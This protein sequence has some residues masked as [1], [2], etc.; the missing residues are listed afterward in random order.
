MSAERETV[1]R[2]VAAFLADRVGAK[3]QARVSGDTRSGLF[4]K[5][6][7]TGAD[8]YVP[9]ATLGEEYYVYDEDN[10]LLVGERTREAYRLGDKVEVRL[11]EAIP[12]AG[13]LRFEVLTP[14]TRLP[15]ALALRKQRR[16]GA[17][18]RPPRGRRR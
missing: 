18:R 4:V 17:P 14:G 11:L 9:A 8:G 16:F 12:S 15:G 10:H 3:F 6:L 7:E 1:D 5:L 13:A 2:L